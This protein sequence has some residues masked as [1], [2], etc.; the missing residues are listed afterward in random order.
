M[1]INMSAS[2]C[3][4]EDEGCKVCDVEATYRIQLDVEDLGM[5]GHYVKLACDE[6]YE[7]LKALVERVNAQ[8]SY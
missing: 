1:K 7:E 6:H 5:W 4:G 3:W 2:K 8:N